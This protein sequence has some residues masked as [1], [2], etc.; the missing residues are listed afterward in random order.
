M[1]KSLL[2]NGHHILDLALR[3]ALVNCI[4]EEMERCKESLQ[5]NILGKSQS[6]ITELL[7]AAAAGM[8]FNDVDPR[9]PAPTARQPTC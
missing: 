1:F 6:E 4:P 9:T 2:E 7:W 5:T 3:T 8:R